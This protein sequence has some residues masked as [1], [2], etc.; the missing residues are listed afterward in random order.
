AAIV[1][2][3]RC[4]GHLLTPDAGAGLRV[5]QVHELLPGPQVPPPNTVPASTSTP[6]AAWRTGSRRWVVLCGAGVQSTT[7]RGER[8]A[9]WSREARSAA[10]A[11]VARLSRCARPARR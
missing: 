1:P 5:G 10:D 6:T 9:A 7:A 3:T 4:P 2:C 11:G 8:S